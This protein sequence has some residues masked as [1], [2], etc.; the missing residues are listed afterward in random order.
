MAEAVFLDTVGLVALL[1]KD[2]E[3]HDAAS[4]LFRSFGTSRRQVLTTNLVLCEV[5]NALARTQLRQEVHWLVRE[6]HREKSAHVIHVDEKLFEAGLQLYGDR[7]D[8]SWGLVDCISF[9][10]MREANIREAFTA[11]RHFAQ[12]GYVALLTAETPPA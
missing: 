7:S 8:K 4:Y 1:N 5:G 9:T 11:D 12:A 6:P 10:V 2:D 3:Y